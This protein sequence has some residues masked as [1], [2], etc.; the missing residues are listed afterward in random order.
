MLCDN[1]HYYY[2]SLLARGG[3]GDRR[4]ACRCGGGGASGAICDPAEAF[5]EVFLKGVGQAS[6]QVALRALRFGRICPTNYVSILRVSSPQREG[7]PRT[8]EVCLQRRSCNLELSRNA[9]VCHLQLVAIY[10]VAIYLSI[11]LSISLSLYI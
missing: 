3:V 2:Y 7:R 10:L 5:G 4:P 8:E 11:Y 6:R 1:T 9:V